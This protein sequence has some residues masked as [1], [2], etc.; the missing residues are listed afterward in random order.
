MIEGFCFFEFSVLTLVLN[1][2][3]SASL[4]PAGGGF[5]GRLARRCVHAERFMLACAFIRDGVSCDL[6]VFIDLLIII[7]LEFAPRCFAWKA[8]CLFFDG[9][10]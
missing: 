5:G 8:T 6:V 3:F 10:A 1:W 7:S 2:L 9:E 4:F